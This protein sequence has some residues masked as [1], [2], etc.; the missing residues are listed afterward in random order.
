MPQ[1]AHDLTGLEKAGILMMSLGASTSAKVMDR[2][3]NQEKSLI[4]TQI[5]KLKHIDQIDKKRVFDEVSGFIK[6]SDTSSKFDMLDEVAAE[7][8]KP[9]KWLENILPD[10][11]A[12]SMQNERPQSVAMVLTQL[13]PKFAS[14]I[15]SMLPEK[16][17]NQ[18]VLRMTSIRPVSED[19]IRAV[20][21]AMKARLNGTKYSKKF[22]GN[23]KLPSI[24]GAATSAVRSAVSHQSKISIPDNTNI[25]S[26]ED[27]VK[28]NNNA[29]KSVLS[30]IENGDLSLALRI[31]SEDTRNF[32][33][34]NVSEETAQALMKELESSAQ[35]TVKSI[36]SAQ[37]RIVNA[38][39]WLKEVGRL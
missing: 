9:L 33:I 35:V 28:L 17:R 1:V 26:I 5:I 30:H 16:Q 18:V 21:E 20:D 24:L 11:V 7:I 37:Q 15:L 31:A 4:T 12:D 38:V 19:A 32:V 34:K 25:E 22:K 10:K 6:S 23:E 2:L 3:N 39:N 27:I 36:Q 13:S 29:I 8:N 14:E